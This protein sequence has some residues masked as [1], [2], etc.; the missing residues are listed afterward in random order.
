MI[1]EITIR[2]VNKT[3]G[4]VKN[5]YHSIANNKQLMKTSGQEIADPQY[6]A[7]MEAVKNNRPFIE[8][9]KSKEPVKES[10]VSTEILTGNQTIVQPNN[11][12]G[13]G[14]STCCVTEE[15]LS[16]RDSIEI[17]KPK[18]TRRTKEQMKQSKLQK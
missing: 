18:R 5:V 7:K 14:S 4:K 3:T 2:V 11:L 13:T 8:N 9:G 6:D 17:I 16:S 10:F 15:D 1:N 12:C